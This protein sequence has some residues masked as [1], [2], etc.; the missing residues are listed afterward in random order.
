MTHPLEQWLSEKKR[1]GERVRKRD[2]AQ[3][4]GC[5][6][7]R[8]SQIINDEKSEPSLTLAAKL[9]EQTGIPISEFVKSGAAQ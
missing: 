6:P 8:I 4:V 3:A 7:S 1:A 9:S 5:S 2:L